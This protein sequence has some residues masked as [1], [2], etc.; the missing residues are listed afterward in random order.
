M[1]HGLFTRGTSVV[2]NLW[3]KKSD[4]LVPV[5]EFLRNF[6]FCRRPV[7]CFNIHELSS[8]M[9][10]V[11]HFS[12]LLTYLLA[13]LHTYYFCKSKLKWPGTG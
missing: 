3:T 6:E 13:C 2:N 10:S 4:S 1:K 7:F 8:I 12:S 11:R 9:V 5:I